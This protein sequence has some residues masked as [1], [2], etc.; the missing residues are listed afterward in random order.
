MKDAISIIRWKPRDIYSQ[1]HRKYFRT[2]VLGNSQHKSSFVQNVF[3]TTSSSQTA[4]T[5][6]ECKDSKNKTT[7]K[8]LEVRMTEELDDWSADCVLLIMRAESENI[9]SLVQT[10]RA[11]LPFAPILLLSDTETD[12]G[13]A[14]DLDLPWSKSL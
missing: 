12:I 11:K 8:Y 6:I 9:R 13:L 3:E 14:S 4:I 1:Q 10:V 2:L 5:T 7:S